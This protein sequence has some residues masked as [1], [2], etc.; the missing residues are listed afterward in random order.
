MVGGVVSSYSEENS[1]V[2]QFYFALMV[3]I[4][5]TASKQDNI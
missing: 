3:Q 2:I 4:S 5:S 1:A